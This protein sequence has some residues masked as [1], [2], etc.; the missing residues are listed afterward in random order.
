M[1]V[2][3]LVCRGCYFDEREITRKVAPHNAVTLA[4]TPVTDASVPFKS[5]FP[6]LELGFRLG[7]PLRQHVSGRKHDVS[8]YQSP[9]TEAS[10]LVLELGNVG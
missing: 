1:W 8:R 2:Q 6:I 10:A 5:C 7:F 3:W 9:G 4:E